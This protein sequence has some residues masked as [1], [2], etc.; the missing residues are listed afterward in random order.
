MIRTYFGARL[1]SVLPNGRPGKSI[2]SID[3]PVQAQGESVTYTADGK[4]LLVGSEGKNQPVYQ[5][6]LPEEARPSPSSTPKNAETTGK[7]E[8]GAGTPPTRGW[9][10]PRAGHRGRGR[11][12]PDAETAVT[13]GNRV[14][15]VA[16]TT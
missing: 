14:T 15:G 16:R 8:E 7:S 1:Y 13:R 3:L 11:L 10:V 12:R 9:V 6:P 4:S 2:K 5:V